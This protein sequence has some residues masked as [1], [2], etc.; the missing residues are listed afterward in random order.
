MK[1]LLKWEKELVM[2]LLP[3]NK[4]DVR[5]FSGKIHILKRDSLTIIL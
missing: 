4:Q 2:L 3:D 5:L 1:Q